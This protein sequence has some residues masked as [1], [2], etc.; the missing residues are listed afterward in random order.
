M[1][2]QQT[3]DK[4]STPRKPY[5]R[6]SI[7]CAQLR[8]DLRYGGMDSAL[9]KQ[10]VGERL[11]LAREALGYTQAA[12]ARLHSLDKTKL[13]HW[14]RGKNLP[15]LAFVQTLWRHHRI[16]ADWLYLGMRDALP[17]RVAANLPAAAG[18]KQAG[19]KAT[20]QSEV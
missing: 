6:E 12:F 13:S 5:R 15:S 9:E 20:E 14:E 8:Q 3:V 11:R 16:S 10:H 2:M 1:S 17:H 4:F 7:N 18:E 19:S